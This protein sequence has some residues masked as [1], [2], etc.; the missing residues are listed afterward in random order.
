M[1]GIHPKSYPFDKCFF[2]DRF[3]CFFKVTNLSMI[4]SEKESEGICGGLNS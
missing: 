1:E 3:P 2:L 4:L